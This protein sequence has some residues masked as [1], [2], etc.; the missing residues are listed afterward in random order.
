MK[1]RFC[2]LPGRMSTLHRLIK[3][4]ISSFFLF[5]RSILKAYLLVLLISLFMSLDQVPWRLPCSAMTGTWDSAGCW[6]HVLTLSYIMVK[7]FK[8]IFALLLNHSDSV[9]SQKSWF[10][11]KCF[12]QMFPTRII[13]PGAY[14]EE[15]CEPVGRIHG[16]G[17]FLSNSF[18]VIHT[19]CGLSFK[20]PV[21]G[22][23]PS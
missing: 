9:S 22:C 13:H 18:T 8:G 3:W 21:L 23:A 14:K 17:A 15:T 2:M 1:N 6:A 10:F 11:L 4:G 7:V 12:L 19:W 5:S 16:G 20:P